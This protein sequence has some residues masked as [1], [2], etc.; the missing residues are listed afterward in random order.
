ML[1]VD[2]V[3]SAQTSL[4]SPK[5]GDIYVIAHRGAHT[6]N[7]PENSLPAYQRAIE[8]GCD[9]VE[10]DVRT[11]LDGVA[12]SIHNETIDAYVNGSSGRVSAMTLAQLRT[13]D[14]CEKV[15]CKQKSVRIPTFDEILKLCKNNIGI[16][17]DLKVADPKMLIDL[18]KK[19]EMEQ[20]IVW[21]VPANR[22][23]TIMTIKTNC[24]QCIVMPD[25]GPEQNIDAV[26]AALQPVILATDMNHLSGS[27][28]DKAH[29]N[30]VLVFTDDN[31]DDP[32]QWKSEW[33]K[34][35]NWGTDGIQTDQPEA[36]INYLTENQ[37]W[38]KNEGK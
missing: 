32:A 19:Y 37:I 31:E 35:I 34:I 21:Y 13:L 3:I 2:G 7:L 11:T 26:I 14:I 8:L 12:V 29:Q 1:F 18:I 22:E 28:V 10:I 30:N 17:L 25:P 36:L 20:D 4:A 38:R 16:Y 33:K 9:F 5:N 6:K 15:D 27:F 24:P 23:K